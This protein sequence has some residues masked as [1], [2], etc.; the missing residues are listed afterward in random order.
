[1]ALPS[2]WAGA[3]PPFLTCEA[4]LVEACFLLR[5]SSGGS[6]AVMQLLAGGIVSAPFCLEE[7]TPAV[8]KLLFRYASVPMSLAD[9]CFVRMAEQYPSAIVMTLDRDFRI[10]R[11]H[12][13][14]VIPVQMP[15]A[16]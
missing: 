12:G 7:E 5:R 8:A 1:M 15:D 11:K 4:V 3:S 13:R 16:C 6:Q 9:G 14:Q 10:Y 2:P